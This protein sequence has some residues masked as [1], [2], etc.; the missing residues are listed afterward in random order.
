MCTLG[1]FWQRGRY[2]GIKNLV[3]DMEEFRWDLQNIKISWEH[4]KGKDSIVKKLVQI[5]QMLV[6][7]RLGGFSNYFCKLVYL[8]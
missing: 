1:F 6:K 3:V 5:P 8:Y 2:P 4:V 7:E